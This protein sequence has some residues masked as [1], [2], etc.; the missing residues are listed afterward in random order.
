MTRISFIMPTFNRAHFIGESLEAIVNQMA[1]DDELLVIDDGSTDD[2]AVAVAAVGG[3]VRYLRQE[4]AGKSVALNRAMAS[5]DGEFVWICDDDD[6]L[7]PGVVDLLV[8]AM[9][10]GEADLVFGRYSRFREKHG[11][12]H[13]L[14]TGY[15][16]DL[17]SGSLPRHILEDAFV[18]QNAA[19]V[20]R[21]AYAQVGPFD[22]TMLR[23]L[24]YEMFVRLAVSVPCRYVDAMI[25]DQRK[26]EGARGPSR[27][28]HA[29]ADSDKVWN[30][31]DRRIFERLWTSLPI[32]FYRTMFAGENPA[33][34]KRAALLQ[35]A[36]VNARHD[37][38]ALT[39][40][41]LEAAA[42]IVPGHLTLTR[43]E[44]EIAHRIVA[45][46]HGFSGALDPQVVARLRILLHGGGAGRQIVRNMVDGLFW[47]FRSGE[48]KFRPF[49]R[50]LLLGVL[51]VR[52]TAVL[53]FEHVLRILTRKRGGGRLRECDPSGRILDRAPT[54]IERAS[55]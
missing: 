17:S 32:E 36:S 16:P 53:A 12:R 44:R 2:T 5:T 47:R 6:V 22:E 26:H 33:T 29:A 34:I 13:D 37:L 27:I 51:G 40:A 3:Q 45:G 52:G 23:S 14:G 25:F 21:S 49:A 15:W 4:N 9:A 24:D 18:M 20:R 42:A 48:K 1:A 50:K 19:L 46:K 11:E 38:W 54:A 10:D 43:L 28:L 8:A 39:I 55:L 35:R 41:D 7:R 30:E 31:W